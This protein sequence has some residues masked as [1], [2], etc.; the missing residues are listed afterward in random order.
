MGR[1]RRL[2]KLTLR[3]VRRSCEGGAIM[4]T[5]IEVGTSQGLLKGQRL[6]GGQGLGR[7]LPWHH[8]PG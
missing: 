2:W 7:H 8:T 1:G 4:L 6:L 3:G 5:A